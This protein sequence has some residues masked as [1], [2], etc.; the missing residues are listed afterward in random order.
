LKINFEPLSSHHFEFTG[1][2]ILH[3]TEAED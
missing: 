3:S 2:K 1:K